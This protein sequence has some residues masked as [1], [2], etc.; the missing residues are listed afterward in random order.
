MRQDNGKPIYYMSLLQLTIITGFVAGFF[1]SL[2]GYFLHYFNFTKV[3]PAIIL[4]IFRGDWKNGWLGVFI[5]CIIYGILSILV[6]LIYY[7]LLRK[8]QSIWL[9]GLY[10]ILILLIVFFVFHPLFTELK[11]IYEYD[12]LTIITEICFFLLY[13]IFIGFSI[14]FEYHEQQYWKNLKTP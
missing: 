9:A 7:L 5:A 11:P 1:G 2:F 10:G 12:L 6:A 14:S 8:K 13:G 3:S 4:A